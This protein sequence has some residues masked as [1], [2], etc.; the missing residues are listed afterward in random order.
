MIEQ[1][2]HS[3]FFAIAS[4]QVDPDAAAAEGPDKH[5][6]EDHGREG[7]HAAGSEDD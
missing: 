2:G 4:R 7:Q 1:Q 6:A 5:R 3:E